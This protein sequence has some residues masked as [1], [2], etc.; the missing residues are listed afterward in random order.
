[1]SMLIDMRTL[2]FQGCVRYVSKPFNRGA[3]IEVRMELGTSP[4]KLRTGE[5]T[6]QIP[7]CDAWIF[8]RGLRYS[9]PIICN[10]PLLTANPQLLGIEER[11]L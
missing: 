11:K 1:M 2:L 8:E 5:M 7:T 3:V 9:V 6:F 4:A 10:D